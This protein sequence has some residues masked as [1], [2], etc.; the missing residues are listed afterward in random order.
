VRLRATLGDAAPLP[1]IE[2]GGN[3]PPRTGI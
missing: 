3:R 1:P 2:G